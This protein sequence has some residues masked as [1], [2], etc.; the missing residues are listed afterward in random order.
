MT[1]EYSELLRISAP[2]FREMW[3]KHR[4]YMGALIT[5][6]ELQLLTSG[7]GA[8]ALPPGQIDGTGAPM[9]SNSQGFLGRHISSEKVLF[10]FNSH[11][12]IAYL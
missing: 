7:H 3:Q 6:S 1:S 5:D 12:S 8:N 10:L 4:Q 9:E 2:H 11:E